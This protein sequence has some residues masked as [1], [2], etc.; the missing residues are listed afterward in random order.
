MALLRRLPLLLL[1]GCGL[2]GGEGGG[3]AHLPTAGAGPYSKPSG[4]AKT[5]AEEP[6]VILDNS[7]DLDDPAAIASARGGFEVWFSRTPTAGGATEIW[8]A[9][10]PGITELPDRGPEPALAATEAWEQGDVEAPSV[11]DLGE[12]HLLMYYQG[13]GGIGRASSDDGGVT[14]SK[15]G[16]VLAGVTDPSAL[17]VDERTFLY[18]ERPDG[19]GLATAEGP[20]GPFVL[21]PEAV[22]T[23]SSGD[24]D[25]FD[26][27]W[28]GEPDV[29]GGKTAANQ[30]H[31]GLFY[32]GRAGNSS[33]AIGHVASADGRMF[34]PSMA[35]KPVLDAGAPD[36]RGP[37]AVLF[38]DRGVL[39]FAQ[40]RAARTV[41]A[42]A[43]T[44]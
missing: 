27:A 22:L 24:P 38:P 31:I 35:G 34:M 14:W 13:G 16:M 39:F 9:H 2:N 25:A 28:V 20:D 18:F 11:V 7:A 43:T 21:V 8:H 17:V 29:V 37:S 36:E 12:G 6:F 5:P 32:V 1:V 19:I 26:R 10:L 30:V 41:I 42:V 23:P 15:D 44:P 33:H 3:D 4:S 40:Q